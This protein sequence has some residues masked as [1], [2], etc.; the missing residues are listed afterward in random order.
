MPTADIW[1]IQTRDFQQVWIQVI[2]ISLLANSLV[3]DI[4]S[5]FVSSFFVDVR[6]GGPH[7]GAVCLNHLFLDRDFGAVVGLAFGSVACDQHVTSR[8]LIDFCML[9]FKR[10]A[11]DETCILAVVAMAC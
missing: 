6:N 11:V 3:Q 4:D 7:G 2:P 10:V 8:C 9:R 1:L 5:T